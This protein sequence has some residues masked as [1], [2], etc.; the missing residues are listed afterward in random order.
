[1]MGWWIVIAQQTPEERD[2]NPDKKSSV[3]ASWESSLG[4][5]DW[6]DELT[7][8]GKATQLTKNGYPTR[9][10]AFACDLVPLLVDGPPKHY[11]LPIIGDGYVMPNG[12]SGNININ[13]EKL[14]TCPPGQILTIDAWDLD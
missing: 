4:G 12:W 1:M 11:D 9:Y 6:L 7:E 13:Q 14:A 10:A 8:R 2:A 3:I 5:L